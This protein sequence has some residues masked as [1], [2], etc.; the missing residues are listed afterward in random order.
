MKF[1][2]V[3]IILCIVLLISF[4][5]LLFFIL[6]KS[7]SKNSNHDIYNINISN[8]DCLTEL[9]GYDFKNAS[10]E[11]IYSNS[12]HKCICVILNQ[13]YN[14][15]SKD[16]FVK[17]NA[18]TSYDNFK[19]VFKYLKTIF[20]DELKM[21]FTDVKN[22]NIAGKYFY[23]QHADYVD[24]IPYY[25][26]WFSIKTEGEEKCIIFAFLPEEIENITMK[27]TKDGSQVS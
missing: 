25:V 3:I 27:M 22:H 2:S 4:F 21:E 17:N 7:F 26:E 13:T 15:F 19:N 5:I 12:S 9:L 10:I 1:K 8:R 24:S 6:H 20:K 11:N 16:K 14:E 23:F 18:L